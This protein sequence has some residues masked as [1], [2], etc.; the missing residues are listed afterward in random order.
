MFFSTPN[1]TLMSDFLL[2]HS[3]FLASGE[4]QKVIESLQSTTSTHRLFT[5]QRDVFSKNKCFRDVSEMP[6]W[7][8]DSLVPSVDKTVQDDVVYLIV[9]FFM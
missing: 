2:K 1:Q 8:D 9:H 4:K 3:H 5:G 6:E 7:Y